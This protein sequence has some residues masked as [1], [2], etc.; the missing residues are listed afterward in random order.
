MADSDQ[1]INGFYKTI[2]I[3][4]NSGS[5]SGGR[6]TVKKEFPNRDTQTIEDLGLRPR[7]YNL[8]IVVAP[9]TAVSNGI[10]STDQSYFDYR[11]SLI[12]ALEDGETGVLVHPLYGRIE[13]VAAT[14]FSINEDFTSFGR[15]TINVVFEVSSDTGIPRQTTTALSQVTTA[16][17]SLA[18]AINTD[19][20]NNFGVSTKFKNN[21]ADAVE[22]IDSIID[23]ATSATSFLS[24]AA[25][26]INSFNS[27]LGE[28]SADVNSLIIAPSDLATSVTNLFSNMDGLFGTV[29]N[30]AKAFKAMFGFGDSDQDDVKTTTA[31]RI[32]RKENRGI[33]NGAINAGTLGYAY[34]NTAQIEFENVNEI[35]TAEDELEVQYQAAILAGSSNDVVDALTDMRV[36]VQD[37]FDEQKTTA[38]QVIEVNVHTLPARV[39]SY[40]YYGESETVD[41]IIA[42]NDISDV[43]FVDGTI[44]IVTA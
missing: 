28:F 37:F 30:T 2:P 19:I 35:E 24:A 34:L 1:I 14:S 11:D 43:S 9:R 6:K 17:S 5:V 31:G 7:T 39:I 3:R 16:N 42:L 13:N 10:T 27:F 18:A 26:E 33:L 41:E 15:T 4:I 44:E 40:Q 12:A 36:I 20:A 29:E 21:F 8:Q 25:E 23:S 32:E 22:K 38:K